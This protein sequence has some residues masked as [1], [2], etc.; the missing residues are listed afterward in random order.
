MSISRWS[1]FG[2]RRHPATRVG[3]S[4]G[5]RPGQRFLR[6]L[7]VERLE[8]RTLLAGNTLV[9]ATPLPPTGAVSE[10]IGAPTTFAYP[11]MVAPPHLRGRYSGAMLGVF[12]L[13]NAVGPAVGVWLWD[14]VGHSFWWWAAVV[15]VMSAVCARIGMRRPEEHPKESPVA[16]PSA[17]PEP[18]T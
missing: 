5:A 4:P 7:Q 15:A 6:R 14:Q 9:A 10:I 1:P 8:D 3:H 11:G 18:A 17:S 13:G 16:E 12:G 2:T